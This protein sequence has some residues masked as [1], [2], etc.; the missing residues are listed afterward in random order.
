MVATL[1]PLSTG[2]I[3]TAAIAH[4]FQKATGYQKDVLKDKDAEHLHQMRVNLRR[5]RTAQQVFAPVLSLPKAAQE[6]Q[7]KAVAR[8][9]GQLRD[10][11][12]IANALVGQYLPDLPKAERKALTRGLKALKQKRRRALKRVKSTLHGKPYRAL[13]KALKAWVQTPQCNG[14]AT[15]PIAIT[16]PDLVLPGVSR[17]WL[18]PGWWQGVTD[19]PSASEERTLASPDLG[20]ATLPEEVLLHSLR[21]HIKQ[22][23]YQLALVS[24]Y[25]GD[26]LTPDLE[27]LQTLQ[28]VLGEL[29]DTSVLQHFLADAIPHWQAQLPTLKALLAANRQRA[30]QQWLPLRQHYTDLAHREALMAILRHPEGADPAPAPGAKK[31]QSDPKAARSK[32]AS[33]QALQSKTA[34]G[35]KTAKAAQGAGKAGGSKTRAKAGSNPTGR[36]PTGRKKTAAQDQGGAAATATPAQPSLG[37]PEPAVNPNATGTEAIA[38]QG[39]DAKV[40]DLSVDPSKAG[41]T[42]PGSKATPTTQKRRSTRSSGTRKRRSSAQPD[43]TAPPA[44]TN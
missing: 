42:Q 31:A 11:D 18:H 34:P 4:F 14:T 16:L 17:L 1:S 32:A 21:K 3:A 44:E 25:Y 39:G 28:T 12:I 24:D 38:A 26:R 35:T 19:L 23:R 40:V 30:W 37:S 9:L 2:A 20:A 6:P 43:P 33:A 36:N 5:L 7:V 22:V 10:L 15:L 41:K 29:Q 13:G 27:R 8:R